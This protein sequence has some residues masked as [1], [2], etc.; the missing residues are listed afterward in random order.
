M[1]IIYFIILLLP[2]LNEFFN[3]LLISGYSKI[4]SHTG[5]RLIIDT[6]AL[7]GINLYLI[8]LFAKEGLTTSLIMS[9]I[10]I[11]TSYLLPTIFFD[12]LTKNIVGRNKKLLLLL[13]VISLLVIITYIIE[14]IVIKYFKD[15]ILDENLIGNEENKVNH[16]KKQLLIKKNQLN[17]N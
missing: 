8:Y 4:Y 16:E 12:K 10:I 15:L 13:F 5:Y 3:T 17:L 1:D 7:V 2:F 6:L 9:F 11:L 14:N